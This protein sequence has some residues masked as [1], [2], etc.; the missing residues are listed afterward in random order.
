PS[1]QLREILAQG[2]DRGGHWSPEAVEAARLLL[3]QRS[4]NLAPEPVYRTA[5]RTQQEAATWARPEMQELEEALTPRVYVTFAAQDLPG[6]TA[7]MQTLARPGGV[8]FGLYLDAQV[9]GGQRHVTTHVYEGGASAGRTVDGMGDATPAP[10][11]T[12]LAEDG[13]HVN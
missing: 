8:T 11:P 5:P 13:W 12:S 10:A 1:E 3:E 2:V 6:A 4:N 7:D 9:A